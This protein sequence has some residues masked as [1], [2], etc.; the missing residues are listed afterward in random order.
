MDLIHAILLQATFW[1]S[2][3]VF[4][5]SMDK[6][7]SFKKRFW[8]SS[9]IVLAC[10]MFNHFVQINTNSFLVLMTKSLLGL[11]LMIWFLHFCWEISWSVAFYDAIWATILWVLLYEDWKVIR[12]LILNRWGAKWLFLLIFFGNIHLH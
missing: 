3:I 4:A 1:T 8:S 7:Q 6:K 10:L 2:G 9:V 12:L 5:S 11:M